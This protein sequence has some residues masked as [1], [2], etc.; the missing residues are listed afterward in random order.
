[1]HFLHFCVYFRN[2]KSDLR[3]L[4]AP[5][6]VLFAV[7]V[8]VRFTNPELVFGFVPFR[9]CFVFVSVAVYACACACACEEG[10]ISLQRKRTPEQ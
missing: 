1:M 9:F 3:S 4:N 10:V 7:W 5:F 8:C 6:S 2:K